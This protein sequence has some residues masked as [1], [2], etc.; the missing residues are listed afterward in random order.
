MPI[1]IINNELKLEVSGFS[2]LASNKNY[3]ATAFGL[4]DCKIA[5]I[6]T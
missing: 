3:G 5:G 6:K 4:T 1:E 2:G